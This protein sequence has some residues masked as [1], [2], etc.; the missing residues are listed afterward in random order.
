MFDHMRVRSELSAMSD[1]VCGCVAGMSDGIRMEMLAQRLLSLRAEIDAILGELAQGE[2]ALLSAEPAL[3]LRSLP[4]VPAEAASAPIT[5]SAA[6]AV[7]ASVAHADADDDLDDVAEVRSEA[8]VS[9]VAR[10]QETEIAY[11]AAPE[12]EYDFDDEDELHMASGTD[13]WSDP[14]TRIAGIDEDMAGALARFGVTTF[15]RIAHWSA[16]DVALIS[17]ELNLG[18]RI[19]RENWI[20]QAALLAEGAL[21]QFARRQTDDAGRHDAPSICPIASCDAESLASCSEAEGYLDALDSE[22]RA[23]AGDGMSVKI[24][25]SEDAAMPAAPALGEQPRAEIIPLELRRETQPA[26]SRRRDRAALRVAAILAALLAAATLLGREQAASGAVEA[27]LPA[28]QPIAGARGET[29]AWL[30]RLWPEG[31]G[32][33]RGTSHPAQE[34]SWTPFGA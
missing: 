26:P 22:G 1:V 7:A 34:P 2:T 6:G 11:E 13:D 4:Q 5:I 10:L 29:W 18:R 17:D 20:E 8:P 32:L 28:S 19:S 31:S 23:H 14:L 33:A 27:L 21:T 25:T 9:L 24:I 15:G 3:A 12:D 16:G 30:V